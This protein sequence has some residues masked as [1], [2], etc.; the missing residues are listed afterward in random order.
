MN[1][2]FNRRPRRTRRRPDAPATMESLEP[3][4]LLNSAP[5]FD[6]AL[7]DRY[8]FD[9]DGQL[10][11]P[12]DVSDAD[13][14][15][16]TV[17]ATSDDP[18]LDALISE[19]NRRA[20]LHF[21][22]DDGQAIGD[23]VIELFDSRS[24][25]AT[26]RFAT[27]A[28]YHV[29]PDGS[30]T[31]DDDPFYTDVPVHRVIDDFM[32][33]TG[34]AENGDGTGGS[35][36]GDFDDDFHPDLEFDRP[37]L[38]AMANSGPDTNDSQFF[39][40]DAP[41]P[42]LNDAHMIFGE[43]L[44]GD[45]VYE[46]II[47][48]PTDAGDHPV[49]PIDFNGADVWREYTDTLTN[50][51]LGALTFDGGAGYTG[52]AEITITLDDGQ[53][54]VTEH[55]LTVAQPGE[56][57]EISM[58]RYERM[59]PGATTD[60]YVQIVDD[61]DEELDV[62]VTTSHAGASVSY[63]ED[64]GDLTIDA[65]AGF[66]GVF[67]ITVSAVE[68]GYDDLDP[69]V[70][71]LYVFAQN[72][73]DPEFTA[74]RELLDAGP[75]LAATVQDGLLFLAAGDA[76]LQVFD[77]TDPE[78]PQLLDSIDTGG[79][80]RQVEVADGAAFVAAGAGG[81]R[82]I[83]VSDPTDLSDL[84][85][86]VG[87]EPAA[88]FFLQGDFA[89]VAEGA[90]G[91]AIYDISDPANIELLGSAADFGD[92]GAIQDAAGVAVRDNWAFVS[93]ATGG[94][95]V[96]DVTDR[97]DPRFVAFRAGDGG[98]QLALTDDALYQADAGGL[99]TYDVS[100]PVFPVL[101]DVADANGLAPTHVSQLTDGV[102]AVGGDG[103]YALMDFDDP[104]DPTVL[105]AFDGVGGA[106]AIDGET[107]LLPYGEIGAVMMDGSELLVEMTEYFHKDEMRVGGG[108]LQFKL[109]DAFVRAYSIRADGAGVHRIEVVP[110]SDKAKV[111][112]QSDGPVTL[113]DILVDGTIACFQ[114][115][116]VNLAG[117]FTATGAI[118]KT[119]VLGDVADDHVI[120]IDGPGDGDAVKITLGDV[121]ETTV[122]SAMPIKQ[123]EANEWLDADG[124]DV[125]GAPW[126][127]KLDIAG[128]FE[129][130]LDLT[131]TGGVDEAL[132]KASI[133]GEASGTWAVAGGAKQLDLHST[134][135]DFAADF[136]GGIRK[137]TTEANLRGEWRAESIGKLDAGG[138]I[139]AADVRTTG[140]IGKV[141]AAA[142]RNA[143]LYAGVAQGLMTLPA[144]PGDFAADAE[145]GKLS[146][147]QVHHS[148][149]AAQTVGKA[150]LDA[151]ETDAGGNPFGLAAGEIGKY[152]GPDA[153]GDYVIRIV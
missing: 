43:M 137:L 60:V 50:D 118:T 65:P 77:L 27:L 11:I 41:T 39:I 26:E 88:D 73:G 75:A 133:G 14:D 89:F 83:D 134:T 6:T 31:M 45:A 9:A 112:I 72:D 148:K 17:T 119:L 8:F 117:D 40:T 120:A 76:G 103:G 101:R 61:G 135:D 85:S 36:L 144:A 129:A 48:T 55:T 102:L 49:T 100:L 51:L 38:V 19:F 78:D 46:E 13:G 106:A 90:A 152:K 150:K 107:V 66:V 115:E 44:S 98:G 68:A 116:T 123:I 15:D 86:A 130:G 34:D 25:T 32:F 67:E 20:T 97:T 54:G 136:A 151:V 33:Q 71:R 111:K 128:P 47:T 109:K 93:D 16:I 139:S 95:F 113:D 114:A 145:I 149:V 57:P 143:F 99:R 30:L 105:Y 141:D 58:P 122:D 110:T 74:V 153:D 132:G 82:A 22:Y 53:G 146:I 10:V 5:V 56:R 125:I 121:A 24:P 1:S 23:I 70:E 21:A 104:Y 12:L 18:A 7:A 80:A 131:G 108:M 37:G 64:T 91:L 124:N 3:R 147:E 29:N 79:S 52:S 63:D 2:R 35:P 94:L 96:L 59:A 81:F 84:D 69:T 28:T 138:W 126:I 62:D 87:A 42:W 127:G 4:L 142:L 140:D 92:D